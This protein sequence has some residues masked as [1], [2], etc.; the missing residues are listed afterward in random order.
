MIKLEGHL[1]GEGAQNRGV[2]GKGI[3]RSEG[4]CMLMPVEKKGEDEYVRGSQ[5]DML[6]WLVAFHDAFGLYGRPGQYSWNASDP[7]SLFFAHPVSLSLSGNPFEG[8][9]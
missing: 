9:T 7:Q 6:K 8:A 1:L 3:A 5:R 4:W 2:T